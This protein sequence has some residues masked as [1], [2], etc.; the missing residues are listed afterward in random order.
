MDFNSSH[1]WTFSKWVPHFEFIQNLE[2]FWNCPNCDWKNYKWDFC[3]DC[4]YWYS[5][6]EKIF[7]IIESENLMTPEEINKEKKYINQ[8]RW[9]ERRSW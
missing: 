9:K 1:W 5:N 3:F 4:N 2:D 8:S 6:K 7:L